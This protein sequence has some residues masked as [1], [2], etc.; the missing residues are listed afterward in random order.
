M[1]SP[2]PVRAATASVRLTDDNMAALNSTQPVF[3]VPYEG[4]FRANALMLEAS[5]RVCLISCDAL[6][7][8]TRVARAASRRIAEAIGIP[9]T[10][11]LICA[12]HQHFGPDTIEK[13]SRPTDYEY[14]RR[15]EEGC[16]LAATQAAAKLAH[17]QAGGEETAVELYFGLSQ[18]AT[19]GSN[20]RP[21]LRDGS[22][23]WSGYQET[24]VVRP[25][26][27]YDPDLHVLALRRADGGYAG[28]LFNHSVHNNVRVVKN[29]W[30]PCFYGMA[31]L[32]LERRL[33][34]TTL[35]LPG[36]CGSTH[37]RTYQLPGSECAYRIVVA[38]QDALSVAE[39]NPPTPLRVLKRPFHYRMRTFDEQTEAAAVDDYLRKYDPKQPGVDQGFFR[40]MREE[41]APFQGE[42]RQIDLQVIR[43]GNVAL[44]GIPGQMF[45]RL[46]L[47]LRR[48]SPFRHT[49]VVGLA[50][51]SV[52][53]IPDQ[54]AYEAGGYQ[55]WVGNA[56]ME[57]G[58]GE[59]MVNQTIDMLYAVH[60]EDTAD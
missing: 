12:T 37:N 21:L 24:D 52:S 41:V 14:I 47:D 7:I 56:L 1:S 51:G 34:A 4:E 36:A 46:G 18:E 31:A 26:G 39:P 6:D 9:S 35:F 28:L 13:A 11:V 16:V 57:P 59:R 25:T 60:G 50:N 3:A 48:R 5:E 42:E 38:V 15:I 19:V 30:S 20:S 8:S 23:G 54:Q 53:Y 33:A 49:I 40:R 32:D 58:S 29:V 10:H 2:V 22:I 17:P 44:V 43:L 55:T 27:P 45:A